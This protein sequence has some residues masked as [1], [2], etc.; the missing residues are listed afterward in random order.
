MFRN[1]F[2]L[3]VIINNRWFF[4]S[5]LAAHRPTLK[6]LQNFTQGGE[7]VNVIQEL[8]AEWERIAVALDFPMS[9]IR[10][11]RQD[12]PRSVYMQC[13]LMFGRWLEQPPVTS[14]PP[15]WRTL[16]SALRDADYQLMAVQLEKQLTS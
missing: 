3:L 2:N 15:T 8:C 14:D 11:I 6:Q 5:S 12:N 7:S 16:V 9:V 1:I 4:P 13:V 10:E